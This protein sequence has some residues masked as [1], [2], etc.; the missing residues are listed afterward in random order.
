MN[1]RP[2]Y[3]LLDHFLRDFISWSVSDK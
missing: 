3:R 1:R 2:K